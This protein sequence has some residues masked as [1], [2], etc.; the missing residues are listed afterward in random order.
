MVHQAY[1]KKRAHTLHFMQVSIKRQSQAPELAQGMSQQLMR[2]RQHH[3][4]IATIPTIN[5]ASHGKRPS[6]SEDATVVASISSLQKR[7]PGCKAEGINNEADLKLLL[8]RTT[9]WIDVLL[10]QLQS[11]TTQTGEAR[12]AAK[13]RGKLLETLLHRGQYMSM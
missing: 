2:Q 12:K 1:T 13:E 6:L 10:E 3:H 4:H 7:I 11:A 9:A 8:S 5:R